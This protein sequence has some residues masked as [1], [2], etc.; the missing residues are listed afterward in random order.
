MGSEWAVV[1]AAAVGATAGGASS[2]VLQFFTFR[3]ERKTRANDRIRVDIVELQDT[4]EG[5]MAATS[6]VMRAHALFPA[7]P[8]SI[9]EFDHQRAGKAS[10]AYS[11]SAR[12]G[13]DELH[14][15]CMAF[16]SLSKSVTLVIIPP[17]EVDAADPM[18]QV[19]ARRGE[20]FSN[21][22]HAFQHVNEHVKVLLQEMK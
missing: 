22:D 6:L 3:N 21:A 13:D 17:E 18:G 1:A 7:N 10:H 11:L 16:L 8:L 5:V 19:K 9:L 15:R 4:L 20:Y 14:R 2:F 12:I